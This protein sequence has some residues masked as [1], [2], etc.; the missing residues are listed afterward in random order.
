MDESNE[1]W[2]KY[3]DA[4]LDKLNLYCR[5]NSNKITQLEK[6]QIETRNISQRI[7]NKQTAHENAQSKREEKQEEREIKSDEMQLKIYNQPQQNWNRIIWLIVAQILLMISPR[8]LGLVG[9]F[10]TSL[11]L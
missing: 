4:E 10:L 9:E 1:W 3:A 5:D 7:E 2:R 11:N 6:D 8:L